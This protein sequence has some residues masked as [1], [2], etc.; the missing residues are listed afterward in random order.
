MS[1]DRKQASERK[2]EKTSKWF[3]AEL[4]AALSLN[5][6]TSGSGQMRRSSRE[7]SESE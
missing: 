4:E 6:V 1:I 5:Y 2:Q 7:I 3:G